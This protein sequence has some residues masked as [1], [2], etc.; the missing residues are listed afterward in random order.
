MDS[1]YSTGLP[2]LAEVSKY[3]SRFWFSLDIKL[4]FSC[5]QKLL[6]G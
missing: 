5:E 3:L 6:L 2:T 4:D 1:A